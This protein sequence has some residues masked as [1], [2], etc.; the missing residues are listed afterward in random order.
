ML[1]CRKCGFMVTKDMGFS[2]RENKCPGC[3]SMLMNN[4][5]LA[6]VKKIKMEIAA[7]RI[8]S[9]S[10]V[11]DDTLTLLSIL[12][13]NKFGKKEEVVGVEEPDEIIESHEEE[14]LD[15]IRAQ[16]R[17]EVLSE[18]SD[19]VSEPDTFESEIERKRSLARS[20][21]FK[22]KTGAMVNRVSS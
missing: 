13:K 21:P 22:K 3:G 17:N 9:A 6:D 18:N 5:F 12:I 16:V 4:E 15:D 2:V 19:L 20:N 10:G 8:L 1:D 14:T 11:S 7:S